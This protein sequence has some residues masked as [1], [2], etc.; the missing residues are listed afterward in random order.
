MKV[1]E[2]LKQYLRENSIQFDYFNK[3]YVP[4]ILDISDDIEIEPSC[5]FL[6]TNTL[7]SMGRLSYSHANLPANTIV[8]R[9][10]SIANS[11]S[12]MGINHPM[13]RFSTSSITYDDSFAIFGDF[14]KSN[15]LKFNPV[16]SLCIDKG[17]VK[18]GHDV[19]IGEAALIARGVSIGTG[20]IIAAR[21]VVTK[22]IP[23]YS[24]VAGI[25]AKIIKYRFSKEVIDRLLYS[26]W[27]NKEV[28]FFNNVLADDE[29]EIFL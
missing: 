12:V 20:A 4:D 8:G 22:D 1:H 26:E 17:R 29:I 10:C 25:P 7:H 13:D 11:V 14:F 28:E 6:N 15:N 24:I 23:P 3:N 5:A 9:F 21:A 2:S 18:I 27:W 16:D 19:W